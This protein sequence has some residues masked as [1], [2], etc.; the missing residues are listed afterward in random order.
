MPSSLFSRP[1]S[2]VW[3]TISWRLGLTKLSMFI[4]AFWWTSLSPS[5][6]PPPVGGQRKYSY[7]ILTDVWAKY[8]VSVFLVFPSVFR[9]AFF[10][11]MSICY[12]YD[13]TKIRWTLQPY[14][15]WELFL[16][17]VNSICLQTMK[18]I[19]GIWTSNPSSSNCTAHLATRWQIPPFRLSEH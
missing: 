1:R 12:W 9:I 7:S 17:P 18:V 11:V 8:H 6:L 19:I 2:P 3:K 13:L 5:P 4:A 10:K 15:K 16:S 14:S